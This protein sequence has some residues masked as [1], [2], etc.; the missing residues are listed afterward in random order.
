MLWMLPVPSARCEVLLTAL[1]STYQPES[2]QFLKLQHQQCKVGNIFL[3]A[4]SLSNPF[5][6]SLKCLPFFRPTHMPPATLPL[7][8]EASYAASTVSS[9]EWRHIY[10]THIT[11][12]IYTVRH[13]SEILQENLGGLKIPCL[14]IIIYN[15]G[16]L[17]FNSSSYPH[18]CE[19]RTTNSFKR[20]SPINATVPRRSLWLTIP[21]SN[22]SRTEPGTVCASRLFV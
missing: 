6:F 9:S 21:S 5:L 19:P 3:S 1:P 20:P 8:A 7:L 10:S 17:S 2:S 13:A 18:V 11:L 4:Y 22:V 16:Q 15:C 12:S 14:G